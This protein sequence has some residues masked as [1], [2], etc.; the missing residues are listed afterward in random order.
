[1]PNEL[2]DIHSRLAIGAEQVRAAVESL[3]ALRAANERQNEE[4]HKLN[5]R[6]TVVESWFD[7][8]KQVREDLSAYREL[9]GRVEQW[10]AETKE[11]LGR[12]IEFVMGLTP[13]TQKISQHD[14]DISRLAQFNARWEAEIAAIQKQFEAIGSMDWKRHGWLIALVTAALSMGVVLVFILLFGNMPWK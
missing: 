12:M 14:V 9:I 13:M 8:I 2:Q 10:Q 5:T 3:A 1:M 4:L 11:G 6:L 7:A